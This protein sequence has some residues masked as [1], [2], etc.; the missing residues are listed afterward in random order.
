M[1]ASTSSSASSMISALRRRRRSERSITA[2]LRFL[3]D[4]APW[5]AAAA[6]WPPSFLAL[7]AAFLP[8]AERSGSSNRRLA[9][10]SRSSAE[11]GGSLSSAA[12]AAAIAT[13]SSPAE[14]SGI[15]PSSSEGAGA[16]S[17]GCA[18][19]AAGAACG[20]ARRMLRPLRAAREASAACGPA[21]WKSSGS[22]SGAK[23]SSSPGAGSAG[24]ACGALCGFCGPASFSNTMTPVGWPSTAGSG[25]GSRTG[26]GA[27]AGR[28]RSEKR[29]VPPAW[30][31]PS[32]ETMSS[33]RSCP[34]RKAMAAGLSRSPSARRR[35][36]SSR[37]LAM[38]AS[39]VS[40]P[41][42]WASAPRL[43]HKSTLGAWPTVAGR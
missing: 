24:A 38:A 11:W 41:M 37:W 7:R 40:G 39:G 15:S 12:R 9:A 43:S 31:W 14:K 20:A 13:G 42:A 34:G 35:T 16:A 32:C 19:T 30:G 22:G 8:G 1:A 28:R 17:S 3:I 23:G 6:G 4:T 21:V 29:P 5:S 25:A 26:S 2:R 27:R 36:R 18:G 33:G 10:C